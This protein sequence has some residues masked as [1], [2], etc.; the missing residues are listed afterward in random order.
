VRKAAYLAVGGMK[1]VLAEN[2][3]DYECWISMCE[4]GWLGVVIPE[5]HY[6]YRIHS[7]SRLRSSNREQLLY[8]YEVIASL[9]S[10]LYHQY[11]IEIY[12]LLNQ[13]GASWLW[14]NPSKN[15]AELNI[16]MTGMEIL[17]LVK[18]KLKKMKSDGGISL[19]LNK[20]L[21]LFKSFLYGLLKADKV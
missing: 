20:L 17:S 1:P 16:D 14:D 12:H 9:H 7:D 21:L 19:I 8:L 10:Q 2:L 3:E 4:Q 13:N 15:T 11:G 6:F 5:L 18:N